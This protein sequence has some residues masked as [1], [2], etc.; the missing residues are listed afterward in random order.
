MVKQDKNGWVRLAA[1]LL[2]AFSL[3]GWVIA[4]TPPLTSQATAISDDALYTA[5][6][7][8]TPGEIQK[9]LEKLDAQRDG[10]RV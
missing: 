10:E 5:E 9:L 1:A 4:K 3:M 8:F 2:A 6:T 7:D